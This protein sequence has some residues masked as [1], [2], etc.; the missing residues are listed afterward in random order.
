MAHKTFTTSCYHG[1]VCKSGYYF[2]TNGNEVKL[3]SNRP[4]EE[5]TLKDEYGNILTFS[6]KAEAAKH[7][8]TN[9]CKISEVLKNAIN[10]E[11]PTVTIRPLKNSKGF[12]LVTGSGELLEFISMSEA[13]RILNT[14]KLKISR[15]LKNKVSGDTVKINKIDYTLK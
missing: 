5:V 11:I 7:F 13:A 10:G 1:K 14:T 3:I 15:A 4:C 6:S 12:T 2:D 8:N 9:N